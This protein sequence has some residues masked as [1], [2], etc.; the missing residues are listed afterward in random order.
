MLLSH[1]RLYSHVELV[2]YR[3]VKPNLGPGHRR[4]RD[5][6]CRWKLK[7]TCIQLYGVRLSLM[8]ELLKQRLNIPEHGPSAVS[9]MAFSPPLKSASFHQSRP[10]DSFT[11]KAVALHSPCGTTSSRHRVSSTVGSSTK[12]HICLSVLPLR[13]MTNSRSGGSQNPDCEVEDIGFRFELIRS[14]FRRL[15]LSRATRRFFSSVPFVPP[16]TV[17]RSLQLKFQT[18]LIT[19]VLTHP[20]RRA[21]TPT[22]SRSGSFSSNTSGGIRS[23]HY[24][25]SGS[26]SLNE[27]P[28]ARPHFCPT[29][30]LF[31]SPELD[32]CAAD[33][34]VFTW[35][36]PALSSDLDVDSDSMKNAHRT[37]SSTLPESTFWVRLKLNQLRLINGWDDIRNVC[38]LDCRLNSVV[39]D[40]CHSC[41][42]N[43]KINIPYHKILSHSHCLFLQL[44]SP[45][46]FRLA[47]HRRFVVHLRVGNSASGSALGSQQV[48]TWPGF[49]SHACDRYWSRF[50]DANV[51]AFV[52]PLST[53]LRRSESQVD[54][55]K[56]EVRF[57]SFYLQFHRTQ[58]AVTL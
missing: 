50:E 53:D 15:S 25:A 37:E 6:E 51:D 49:R 24:A 12:L 29:A 11:A 57:T 2:Y 14:V 5:E 46:W 48:T 56:P 32:H 54:S 34:A 3:R 55:K 10:S 42:I 41:R 21:P 33:D 9:G 28:S 8:E 38:A 35:S 18:L 52:D 22:P 23:P 13:Q 19:G 4:V 45:S 30:K 26:A 40:V 39:L 31:S 58:T 1:T 17:Y 27:L 7:S 44:N 36:F 47:H 20:R 16:L 43:S